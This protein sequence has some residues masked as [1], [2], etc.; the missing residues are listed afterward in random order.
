MFTIEALEEGIIK[1]D[2]NIVIFEEAIKKE[3]EQQKVW[4]E[5]IKEAGR[6]EDKR[7]LVANGVKLEA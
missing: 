5:Q 7:D 3:R 6:M 4:R 1:S 2:A